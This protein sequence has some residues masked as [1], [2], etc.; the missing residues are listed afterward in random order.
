MPKKIEYLSQELKDKRLSWQRSRSQAK[1]RG[2]KWD[3]TFD[4]YCELWPTELWQNRGRQG[5]SYVLSRENNRK[6]WTFSNC[7]IIYRRNQ[8]IINGQKNGK[9]VKTS[10]SDYVQLAE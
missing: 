2:E 5:D 6:P 1:Y 7:I 10:L 8:L 9:K 3:L 4:E